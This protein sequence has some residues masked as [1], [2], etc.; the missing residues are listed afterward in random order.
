MVEHEGI[1]VSLELSNVGLF[2]GFDIEEHRDRVAKD[3][4]SV[5]RG[6]KVGGESSAGDAVHERGEKLIRRNWE[7]FDKALEGA[8]V[9]G[10]TKCIE[11]ET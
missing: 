6:D 7:W 10:E 5:F 1:K 11:F 4:V 9:E 3:I 2:F 8:S